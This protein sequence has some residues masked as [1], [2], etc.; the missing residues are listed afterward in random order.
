MTTQRFY[1]K[2]WGKQCVNF[3][4][5]CP[6]VECQGHVKSLSSQAAASD[7]SQAAFFGLPYA[8]AGC[9]LV[10]QQA[11]P[12]SRSVGILDTCLWDHHI[13]TL[14]SLPNVHDRALALARACQH[15][16]ALVQYHDTASEKARRGNCSHASESN[17]WPVGS[18]AINAPVSSTVVPL[19][20]S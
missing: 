10:G 1:G 12:C 6:G 9:L 4:K 17:L 15:G 13:S 16:K 11:A 3:W 18:A 20:A 14:T 2:P 8:T 7:I 19:L 5:S